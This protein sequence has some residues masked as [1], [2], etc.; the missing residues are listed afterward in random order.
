MEG[1][2][3]KQWPPTGHQQLYKDLKPDDLTRE[4]IT[5]RLT[6]F[7]EN[8][9]RRPLKEADLAPVITMVNGKLNAGLAPLD[10]LKLG[11]QTILCSPGFIYLSEGEGPLD[12]PCIGIATVVFPMVIGSRQRATDRGAERKTFR[13]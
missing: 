13:P 9:F 4:T 2:H 12:N 1:P 3:I 7:A 5:N 8:A 11:F 6:A 10:A